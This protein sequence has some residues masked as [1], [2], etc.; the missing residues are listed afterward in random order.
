MEGN[1][2]WEPWALN[3]SQC[4]ICNLFPQVFNISTVFWFGLF[5]CL[6]FF[7]R[8]ERKERKTVPYFRNNVC[9]QTSTVCALKQFT[10]IQYILNYF[11]NCHLPKETSNS[12]EDEN[13]WPILLIIYIYCRLCYKCTRHGISQLFHSIKKTQNNNKKQHTTDQFFLVHWKHIFHRNKHILQPF[14][15]FLYFD[16]IKGT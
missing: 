4:D 3:S 8:E 15:F 11:L 12:S 10:L 5:V 7:L 6:V 13:Y 1:I 2:C 14:L 9:W 16:K